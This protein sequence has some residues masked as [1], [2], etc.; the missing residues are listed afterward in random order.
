[1]TVLNLNSLFYIEDFLLLLKYKLLTLVHN[2]KIPGYI[3][4]KGNV[5]IKSF[6]TILYIDIF[7]LNMHACSKQ[8]GKLF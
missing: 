7:L 6:K 1:M 5:E 4:R 8:Q 2:N 3:D